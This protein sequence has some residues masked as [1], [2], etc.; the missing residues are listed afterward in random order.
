MPAKIAFSA[1]IAEQRHRDPDDTCDCPATSGEKLAAGERHVPERGV[2]SHPSALKALA[3]SR[4]AR[5]RA[6][7]EA[8]GDERERDRCDT[9]LEGIRTAERD[10]VIGRNRGDESEPL[11]QRV[12]LLAPSRQ[13]PTC[14]PEWRRGET[15]DGGPA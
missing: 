4:A 5:L 7:R 1:R 6:G 15:G 2:L 3:G 14:P 12:P 13:G 11:P 9:H 8:A 10:Q